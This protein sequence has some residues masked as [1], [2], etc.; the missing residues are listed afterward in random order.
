[1]PTI[2]QHNSW[3]VP[4]RTAKGTISSMNDKDWNSPIKNSLREDRNALINTN[5]G[6]I[7]L[8]HYA[9]SQHYRLMK[10]SSI[11]FETSQSISM[12]LNRETKCQMIKFSYQTQ[13]LLPLWVD[14]PLPV[15]MLAS[16]PLLRYW[17]PCLH[18]LEDPGAAGTA[19][20]KIHLHVQ[21]LLNC[22]Q[23]FLMDFADPNKQDVFHMKL[24]WGCYPFVSTDGIVQLKGS[25]HYRPNSSMPHLR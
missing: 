2:K 22:L 18:C 6:A 15:C 11:A 21:F 13:W 17:L 5:Q 9:I 14:A 7:N 3:S 23:T 20:K 1:M 8:Y 16:T 24:H 19:R 25:V 10:T 12:W 4:R